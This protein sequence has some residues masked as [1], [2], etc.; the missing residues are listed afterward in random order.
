MVETVPFLAKALMMAACQVGEV[1]RLFSLE[2]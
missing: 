2:R 1:R